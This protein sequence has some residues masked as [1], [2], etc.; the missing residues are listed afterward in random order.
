MEIAFA[1]DDNYVN[2][3][4][5][6]IDSLF[7]ENADSQVNVHVLSNGISTEGADKVKHLVKCL[8]H[9][10]TFYDISNLKSRLANLKV[11][12]MSLSSYARLFVT[13]LLPENISKLI[14]LDSDGLICGSLTELWE[15]DMKDNLIAGVEDM[16][17]DNYKTIIGVPV[18]NPYVNAGMLMLNLS[19]LRQENWQEKIRD[20]ISSKKVI[21][22]HDQGVI[23]SLFY[24][25]ALILHPKF[26]CLTPI[27]FLNNT[28]ICN[29]YRLRKYYKDDLLNEA[30]KNP[31]FVHFTPFFV[32]RPWTKNSKHPLARKYA[33]SYK[34]VLNH[35]LQ[36]DSRS[37]KVKYLSKLFSA[38]P[39]PLFM[40]LYRIA[41]FFAIKG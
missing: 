24:R 36:N 14:Y 32:A 23:N 22:H 2:Y 15:T 31:I 37:F 9:T 4:I 39:L 41:V 34:N 25:R 10:I 5:V 40:P 11:G 21:P 16:V 29:L 8:N 27:F 19:L 20:F 38:L 28:Q 26:N 18:E 7:K 17:D 6:A 30:V 1:S 13:E 3:M 35:A 33:D 12:A